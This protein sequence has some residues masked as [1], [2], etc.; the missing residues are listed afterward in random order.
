MA[1]R[2]TIA[3]WVGDLK[4]GMVLAREVLAAN[5]TVLLEQGTRLTAEYLTN[6][7]KWG[8][9]F[10]EVMNDA[11]L[12]K[13]SQ[14]EMSREEFNKLYS[15]TVA[16]VKEAFEKVRMFQELPVGKMLKLSGGNIETMINTVGVLD[17]LQGVR[18]H[19]EYT[20]KHSI[21][22][23]IISGLIGRWF[24]YEG[25]ELSELVLTGL[26]HDI[27]KALVPLTILNKPGK[28]SAVEMD[29]IK[30]HPAAGHHLVFDSASISEAVRD[31]I[32]HHHERLDGSGYPAG[33]EDGQ[34][35]TFARIVAIAD[36]YDAMTSDRVYRKKLTPFVAAETI[37]QQMYD[38]LDPDISLT[39]LHNI[40]N[41]L[42]GSA[43]S[44]NNGQKGE[45]V[46]INTFP[47]MQILI[48]T[49][50][51]VV[52]DLEKNPLVKIVELI[53]PSSL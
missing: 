40:R 50:D 52:I 46:Y 32:M 43:V 23:A 35:G 45:V 18:A 15:E 24:G 2:D 17:Y 42:L 8:I 48:K 47:I 49:V 20:F 16:I 38:Q 51:G 1:E 4:P 21:N 14:L 37:L 33:L 11:K 6:L 28:L 34:V 29:V 30:T 12:G 9:S 39:F 36:I 19:C 22:V 13:E 27:G 10:V 3:M 44:L 7:N 5:R 26:L 41:H 53:E 25:E 31:G